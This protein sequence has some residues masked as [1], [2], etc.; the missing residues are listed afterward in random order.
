[1]LYYKYAKKFAKSLYYI[2]GKKNKKCIK[3]FYIFY[4]IVVFIFY[5]W[6]D[7]WKDLDQDLDS[8]P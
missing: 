8:E 1:M 3:Y 4:S 5:S 2:L 6:K 7:L